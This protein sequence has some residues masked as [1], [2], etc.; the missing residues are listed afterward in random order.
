MPNSHTDLS[1]RKWLGASSAAGAGLLATPVAAAQGSGSAAGVRTYNIRDFGAKGDGTTLDT[2]ALQAAID[3]CHKD[4]GGTVL[5]PAG[6]FVIGTVEMKSNVT[7]HIAAAGTLLGAAD[8]QY[9]AAE[10]IPLNGDSTLNDGNVG[11]IY[12]VDAENIVIE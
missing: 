10:A 4:Q 9:H 5:V 6:V 8:K 11:L 3:A 1:R 2:A 12:A 7:L